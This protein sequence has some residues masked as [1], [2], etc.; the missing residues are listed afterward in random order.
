MDD[1]PAELFAALWPGQA[2]TP[3]IDLP[4]LAERSGVGR[5][6][7]KDESRRPLGN[8]KSLGGTYAALRALARTCGD[9]TLATLLDA[10][11]TQRGVPALICAS[12]GNHGLAVAAAAEIAGAKA[13]IFLHAGV[14]GERVRRLEDR[15]AELV[16]VDGVYD[17]AVEAAAQ[18]AAAGEGLLIADVSDRTDDLALGDVMA[19][20]DVIAEETVRQLPDHGDV[21]VSH[22]FVQGGVGGLAA[23]L[24]QGLHQRLAKPP[25]VVVVEPAAA[26]CVAA[27]LAAGR[28]VRLAGNLASVAEMLACGQ[29]SAPA[30]ELLLRYRAAAIGVDDATLVEAVRRLAQAGGPATTPSGAA[31]LAGLIAATAGT[32]EDLVSGLAARSQVLLVVT[33]GSD[34]GAS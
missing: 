16:R 8:F 23:A 18:A 32:A 26:R 4:A 11:A 17:D 25:Q 5:V 9:A 31:G 29:V 10:R 15:G 33:E 28:P 30:L 19:G 7:V 12:A 34:A 2:P 6:V 20:Y 1:R 14:S 24:A 3:L 27:G 21:E 22:V 13:R